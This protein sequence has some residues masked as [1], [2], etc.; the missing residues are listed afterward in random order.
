MLA[1][2]FSCHRFAGFDAEAVR[3]Y[4]HAYHA[5]DPLLPEEIA[6][7]PLY[8]GKECLRRIHFLLRL[9]FI[10]GD[11]SWNFE[12]ERK[13]AVWREAMAHCDHYEEV[14]T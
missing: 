11:S 10:D 2:A 6:A 9:H 1:I 4:L 12:L 8:L 7:Y 5:A 3:A 14:L 13:L